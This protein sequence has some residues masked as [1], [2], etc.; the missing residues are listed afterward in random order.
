[1]LFVRGTVGDE[2]DE[3]RRRWDPAMAGRIDPHL[4]L[5]HEVADRAA[6]LGRVAELARRT[7]PV[8]ITLTQAA[9]WVENPSYGV[10]LGVDDVAG[11]IADLHAALADLETPAWARVPF[12]P[13][14]TV[15]HGR[16]VDPDLAEPAWAALCRWRVDETVTLGALDV[17]EL[18]DAT[19]WTSVQ[20]AALTRLRPDS[21][22]AG[23]QN[24]DVNEVGSGG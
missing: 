13:H 24:P 18:D 23:D 12:H 15:V 19:G 8:T 6:A 17:I 4:T 1:M 22:R 3:V 21:G 2:I 10:Y 20:T 7:A 11:G 9:C 16:T 14:V 5:V